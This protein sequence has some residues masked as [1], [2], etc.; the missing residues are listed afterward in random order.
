MEVRRPDG[1][2]AYV[3]FASV[4]IVSLK[5]GVL[6]AAEPSIEEPR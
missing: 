3:P 6:P 2:V 5:P 4:G 1:Q